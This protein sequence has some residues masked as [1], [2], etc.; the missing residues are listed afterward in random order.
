MQHIYSPFVIY[1]GHPTSKQPGVAHST[2]STSTTN[3][4][5]LHCATQAPPLPLHSMQSWDVGFTIIVSCTALPLA[6][7]QEPETGDGGM[8][9]PR[10]PRLILQGP[11][12]AHTPLSKQPYY[13][14]KILTL[15]AIKQFST[16][17]EHL[18]YRLW[19]EGWRFEKSKRSHFP[20]CDHFDSVCQ[21]VQPLNYSCM[22]EPLKPLLNTMLTV[23]YFSGL[24][25]SLHHIISECFLRKILWKGKALHKRTV[26]LP[27]KNWFFVYV[28]VLYIFKQPPQ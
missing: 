3:A 2:G 10:D 26:S 9:K 1:Q 7:G 18:S 21:S 20:D 15:Y 16:N 12:I 23:E 4:T 6:W 11:H 27:F 22:T 8:Q 28:Y 25:T 13:T 24:P 5:L 14:L 19:K 17:Y